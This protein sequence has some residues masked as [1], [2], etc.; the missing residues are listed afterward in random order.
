MTDFQLAAEEGAFPAEGVVEVKYDG[1][2]VR[3]DRGRLLARPQRENPVGE[4]V[5]DRF[6][7][8]V[9][10]E[11]EV[12]GEVVCFTK[13]GGLSGDF[14]AILHYKTDNPA[15]LALAR[16]LYPPTLL[17]FDVTAWDCVSLTR[18]PLR[19]RL[20]YVAR[21][22]ELCADPH[23]VQPL[24]WTL[25]P[26]LVDSLM[27]RVRERHGEGLI[28]KDLDAPYAP[29]KRSAAWVKVKAWEV[30]DLPY[31]RHGI[32]AKGGFVV[33][34]RSGERE[35]EVVVNDLALQQRIAR[36]VRTV[37]VRYLRERHGALRQGHV[38]G[39]VG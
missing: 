8:C 14:D 39:G 5:T 6:S 23:V 4:D 34:V 7:F 35:Q 3:S 24:R 21:A 11:I 31:L 22:G 32:T 33:V 25:R 12:V 36:G 30:A 15:K 10:P 20:T 13:D 16:Q 9:P 2:M 19:D 28:V 29:G 17:V 18:L 26:G 27:A 38:T 1:M 37:Q